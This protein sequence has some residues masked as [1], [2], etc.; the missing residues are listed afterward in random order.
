MIAR[1]DGS[2]ALLI[3]EGKAY[4]LR[5]ILKMDRLDLGGMGLHHERRADLEGRISR[6][7]VRLADIERQIAAFR[8]W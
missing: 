6:N 2:G 8:G 1:I 4:R 7:Y 3:A 5:H